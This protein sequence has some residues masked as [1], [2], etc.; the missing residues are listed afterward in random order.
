[1]TDIVGAALERLADECGSDGHR[2]C[3]STMGCLATLE[4]HNAARRREE[5]AR[6]FDVGRVRARHGDGLPAH[7][8]ST[9][10][11]MR[12]V[13]DRVLAAPFRDPLRRSIAVTLGLARLGERGLPPD[14]IIRTCLGP[15]LIRQILVQAA[16]FWCAERQGRLERK[17]LKPNLVGWLEL[18]DRE[19][20]ISGLDGS[21]M[22]PVAVAALAG[23]PAEAALEWV[24]T[25]AVGHIVGWR[26]D[27]YLRVG[28][29]V[30][31]FV[32]PAG[33][34]ATRWIFDRFT[35][36]YPDQWLIASHPWEL[37][38]N[39]RPA[40]TANR[41][42]LSLSLLEERIVT[43]DAIIGA[44]DRLLTSPRDQDVVEGG[45]RIT[46]VFE[47]IVA[48]LEAREFQ[49]A[50][51]LAR[52]S[53]EASPGVSSFRL[54]YAFCTIPFHPHEAR[55]A[56]DGLEPAG[57]TEEALREINRV[58]C[59]LFD[60]DAA[61]ARDLLSGLKDRDLGGDAAWL[62]DPNEAVS[63]VPVVRYMTLELWIA[64]VLVLLSET[65]QEST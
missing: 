52:Q 35:K 59:A 20:R 38:F 40:M 50:S 46:E 33:K 62:W 53:C 19:E 5:A 3:G 56:L 65:D 55:V 54:F 37:V 21:E 22:T 7:D 28:R 24:R 32:L 61:S 23:S 42:G 4:A 63:G 45:L 49:S 34:D 1:M 10:A 26:I 44:L 18:L 25:A 36:T 6:G 30:E 31:D 41:V 64:S 39:R 48:L 57:A 43:D 11:L 8:W 9:T 14:A 60:H 12:E 16:S 2:I 51:I 27:G 29:T 13:N 15:T 47:A 17:S 58:S